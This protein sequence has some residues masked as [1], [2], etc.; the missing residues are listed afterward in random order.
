MESWNVIEPKEQERIW[1]VA[2]ALLARSDD[3]PANLTEALQRA[4]AEYFAA[5]QALTKGVRFYV[6]EA[7]EE[8]VR[9]VRE[10]ENGTWVDEPSRAKTRPDGADPEADGR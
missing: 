7:G 4:C 8:R 9:R 10:L 3:P 6:L 1:D 2:L 5:R